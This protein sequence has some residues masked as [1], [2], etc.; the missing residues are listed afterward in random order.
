MRKLLILY[1]ATL[2]TAS[3]FAAD[4]IKYTLNSNWNFHPGGLESI[5]KQSYRGL[6]VRMD[7]LWERI[8]LP[9]TWNGR[10]PFDDDNTYYRG[11]GWYTRELMIDSLMQDKELF[12]YFEGVNQIAEVYVNGAFA[13]EHQGGYTAFCFNITDDIIVGGKNHIAVKV[14]NSHNHAIPPLS[15]GY[16]LYGGIYRDVWIIGVNQVHFD[17]EDYASSGVYITT[18]NVSERSAE[19]SLEYTVV[20][21]SERERDVEVIHSLRNSK[22]GAIIKRIRQVLSVPAGGQTTGREEHITI[23]DPRLWSPD[24]PFLYRVESEVVIQGETV[25]RVSN[26]LGFRW[27]SFDP[28]SGFFLNGQKL[29]LKGTNRH[30]DLEGMGSA[31][32]NAR[33]RSDLMCIKDMGANFLRLAHYPQDPEVLRTADELGLLIW[34][35][36]PLVNHIDTS[37]SFEKNT[38]K[39]IKEMIRQHY[40]HPSIIMWGSCNEIFLM[41]QHGDRASRQTD[42]RYAS[43]TAAFIYRLD[44]LIRKEDPARITTLAMHVSDDYAAYGIDT[45]AMVNAYNIYNGWYGDSVDG[46][47]ELLDKLHRKYPDRP[48]FVSEYGA[49][50]DVRINSI[51]PERF[52]FSN[53]YQLKFHE[54]YLQQIRDRRWLAGSAIWSQNDFSQPNTGGTIIH[55][56]QKGVQLWDRRP[57]DLYFFYK[58]NWCGDPMLYIA[59]KYWK[60]R[61]YTADRRGNEC[62][63]LTRKHTIRVYSNTEK[64]EL[65]HN[66]RSLGMK[67]PDRTNKTEWV[68]NLKDGTNYFLAQSGKGSSRIQD[69]MQISLTRQ[70]LDLSSDHEICINAG[71]TSFFTDDEGLLWLPDREYVACRYGHTGGECKMIPKDLTIFNAKR[72]LPLYNYYLEGLARYRVD[73]ADGL[74]QVELYFTEV[75]P[76]VGKGERLFDISMNGKK[77]VDDLDIFGTAGFGRVLQLSY[78]VK[79]EGDDGL[80]IDFLSERAK[81]ILCAIRI[82]RK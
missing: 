67:V 41:D 68:V 56:N 71:N 17:L 49:G 70:E 62:P 29:V 15:V 4:R 66:S 14:D 16:A 59:D 73:L 35:E 50:G 33:H 76:G 55:L 30:Q 34:E 80:A 61:V 18:E 72:S 27:F 53:Q 60:D 81:T 48:I 31:L 51:R 42:E 24:D 12:L 7:V 74:Y 65:I 46:F 37:A 20:N 6:P 79:C 3:G 1:I 25:D 28:D 36:I 9:H 47:G 75:D 5:H 82:I 58:A 78:Q 57:K 21:D 23:Q 26:P 44:R 38:R 77:M 11:I 69:C 52:D 45:I 19:I 13:G 22:D 63:P 32:T 64:V 40:N 39:M 8:S 54:S 10:D 43:R 2:L